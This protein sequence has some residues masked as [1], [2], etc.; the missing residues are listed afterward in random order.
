MLSKNIKIK[1]YRNIILPTCFVWMSK[2]VTHTEGG[3]WA[4]GV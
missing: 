4:E 1:I 2:L 3:I